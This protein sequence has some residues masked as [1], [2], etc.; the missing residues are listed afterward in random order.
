MLTFLTEKPSITITNWLASQFN[1][2][3][4]TMISLP[5]DY[6]LVASLLA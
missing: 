3:S 4:S 2:H 6:V 5:K 1:K